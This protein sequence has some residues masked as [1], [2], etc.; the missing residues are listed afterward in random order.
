MPSFSLIFTAIRE[1]P[2]FKPVSINKTQQT[3]TPY[4]GVVAQLAERPPPEFYWR[5]EA[6]L[7]DDY[8]LRR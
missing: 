6:F 3:Q 1:K 7:A 8:I 4:T 5:D 2:D